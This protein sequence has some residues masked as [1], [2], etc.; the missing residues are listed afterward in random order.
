MAT[1]SSSAANAERLAAERQ[2]TAAVA[3]CIWVISISVAAT[4]SAEPMPT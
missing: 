3:A 1:T 4:S 2:N